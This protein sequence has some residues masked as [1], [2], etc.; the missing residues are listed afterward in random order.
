MGKRKRRKSPITDDA[1]S[2]VSRPH[3]GEQVYVTG[4]FDDWT[5]SIKLD[6]VG[7]VFEKEVTFP[8]KGEKIYYKVRSPFFFFFSRPNC[9]PT[10]PPYRRPFL[11]LASLHSIRLPAAD[12][13]SL[14]ALDRRRHTI[15]ALVLPL[16]LSDVSGGRHSSPLRAP[17]AV[18]VRP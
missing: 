8:D 9:G 18:T 7:D 17:P 12:W 13:P 3:A 11:S 14:A 1:L 4:T 2:A 6:K 10:S 5:K 15:G 16:P